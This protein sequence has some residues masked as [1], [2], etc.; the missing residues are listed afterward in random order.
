ME[1]YILIDKEK[2]YYA[3]VELYHGRKKI[4][5]EIAKENLQIFYSIIEETDIKY[6]LIYGTLLG[7][8]RENN[9]IEHDEDID[10]FVLSEYK[11]DFLRLLGQLKMEGLEL[12][13]YNNDVISLM[14]KNE[15]IDIFFY[16]SRNKFGFKK[17][18]VLNNNY[19]IDAKYLE[20]I[21]KIDFLGMNISVPQDSEGLLV[22]IYGKN[23]K[24]PII[25]FNA[26]PNAFHAKVI[27]L[28]PSIIK[29]SAYSFLSN[30]YKKIFGYKS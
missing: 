14:R 12:V 20:Q 9:F 25:N 6:G 2:F 3:E 16:V 13:R 26:K 17:I 1:K 27:S 29:S 18:R 11:S 5:R 23:W 10:I 28:F 30:K 24:I 21:K 15:Y 22:K 8:I 19:E 4:D 7:A